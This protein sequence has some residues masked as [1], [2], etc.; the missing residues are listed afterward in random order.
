MTTVL[1]PIVS[2][3]ATVEEAEAY[4]AWKR[5]K[6]EKSMADPRPGIPH[7]QVMAKAQALL[8]AKKRKHAQAGL[9]KAS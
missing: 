3:F 8:D 2:E 6:I 5:A 4:E 9:D 7:D 1:S